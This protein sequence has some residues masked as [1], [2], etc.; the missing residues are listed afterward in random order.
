MSK[1]D[2]Y[3]STS[4]NEKSIIQK[5]INNIK[6]CFKPKLSFVVTQSIINFKKF[7]RGFIVKE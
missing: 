5:I 2:S 3:K 6:I 4:E 1:T 7:F